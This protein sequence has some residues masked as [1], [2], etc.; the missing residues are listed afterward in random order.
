MKNVYQIHGMTQP[1]PK[2][3]IRFSLYGHIGWHY[4]IAVL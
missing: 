2:D 4:T 1:V 3:S